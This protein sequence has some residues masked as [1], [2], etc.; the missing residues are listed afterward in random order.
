[1][2]LWINEL[3]GQLVCKPTVQAIRHLA[4]PRDKR[5]PALVK[6]EKGL[7]GVEGHPAWGTASFSLFAMML[8][9]DTTEAHWCPV[10]TPPL[11][12]T[13]TIQLDV[14]SIQRNNH[15]NERPHVLNTLLMAA[16]QG[17]T[18]CFANWS[19]QTFEGLTPL[20]CSADGKL[21]FYSHDMSEEVKVWSSIT[22]DFLPNHDR[23]FDRFVL[24][25]DD[26]GSLSVR[27]LDTD[28]E[29]MVTT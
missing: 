1:M 16:Q 29:W 5:Y 11:D 26:Q 13:I 23:D 17:R 12:N 27:D 14:A 21:A 25:E 6:T 10:K 7:G 4:L 2:S 18:Y 20:G 15:V 19:V 22:S 24:V 9:T 3:N 8:S 28:T